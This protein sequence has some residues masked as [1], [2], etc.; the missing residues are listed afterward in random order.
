MFPYSIREAGVKA[1]EEI[2]LW[3]C[4]LR[5]LMR[6]GC[7]EILFHNTP[8]LHFRTGFLKLE[9]K[10]RIS[11]LAPH[12]FAFLFTLFF[13]VSFLL[14]VLEISLMTHRKISPPQKD[15]KF[16][17]SKIG[18]GNFLEI[19][20]YVFYLEIH[21]VDAMSSNSTSKIYVKQAHVSPSL[22]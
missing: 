2:S 20:L 12:F 21:F 19:S 4:P 14:A 8:L 1:R 22:T 18:L 6:R 15:G 7:N 9:I 16:Q 5:N 13:L 3:A 11:F 10:W 17:I